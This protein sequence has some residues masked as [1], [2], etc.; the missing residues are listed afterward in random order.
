MSASPT[1]ERAK[2]PGL[3]Q[4]RL[5]SWQQIAGKVK[6]EH[7]TKPLAT[8]EAKLQV[9]T[10]GVR[11][12]N[13]PRFGNPDDVFRLALRSHGANVGA[14][15]QLSAPDARRGARTSMVRTQWEEK[16]AP[17]L[18]TWEASDSDSEDEQGPSKV[19]RSFKNPDGRDPHAPSTSGANGHAA[20]SAASKHE[21]SLPP[22]APAAAEGSA[23]NPASSQHPLRIPTADLADVDRMPCTPAAAGSAVASCSEGGGEDSF[24]VPRAEQLLQALRDTSSGSKSR[25]HAA[26]G[27][28]GGSHTESAWS[29][30]RTT[31]LMVEVPPMVPSA[32]S[33]PDSG[34]FPGTRS[35]PQSPGPLSATVAR[36]SRW[37]RRGTR[38]SSVAEYSGGGLPRP[39]LASPPPPSPPAFAAASE[40][41]GLE[42][43]RTAASFTCGQDAR[44]H[45]R[46]MWG[47]TGTRADPGRNPAAAIPSSASPRPGGGDAADVWSPDGGDGNAGSAGNSPT[48]RQG[49]PAPQATAS[50]GISRRGSLGYS[51]GG[52]GG[53]GGAGDGGHLFSQISRSPLRVAPAQEWVAVLDGPPL[54]P[55]GSQ[56]LFAAAS[57]GASPYTVRDPGSPGLAGR[58]SIFAGSG[59]G[60]GGGM[61][62]AEERAVRSSVAAAAAA[63]VNVA[64]TRGTFGA[65]AA[66]ALAKL[67]TGWFLPTPDR[68]PPP[69]R[70]AR[71]SPSR[72]ASRAG[73]RTPS[74]TGQ[75]LVPTTPS[76]PPSGA[77]RVASPARSEMASRD[78]LRPGS[79]IRRLPALSTSF[80]VPGSNT[81][82]ASGGMYPSPPASPHY[83]GFAGAPTRSSPSFSSPLPAAMSAAPG[84]GAALPAFASR[85][86]QPFP[87]PS[88]SGEAPQLGA[89]ALSSPGAARANLLSSPLRK[90]TAY[91][92]TDGAASEP[93]ARADARPATGNSA[94]AAAAA[95][96]AAA[97]GRGGSIQEMCGKL[98]DLIARGSGSSS[99]KQREAGGADGTII[100]TDADALSDD[101]A[102]DNDSWS[103]QLHSGAMAGG[104]GQ[105]L[106]LE[107]LACWAEQVE[108]VGGE[109][110]EAKARE[111]EQKLERAGLVGDLQ[112]L[113][114]RGHGVPSASTGGRG[115]GNGGPRKGMMDR[116]RHALGAPAG[117]V[118]EVEVE[119]AD[120]GRTDLG[121]GA[122]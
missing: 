14:S 87:P 66:E 8:H 33:S 122:K 115:A 37:F 38:A 18:L 58:T 97:S 112:E 47:S 119:R 32:D 103:G 83:G 72:S 7:I 6:R 68:T 9:S 30:P 99:G 85:S 79:A 89:S 67:P 62:T 71:S 93:L 74:V 108:Q 22:V 40:S 39:S 50:G 44:L 56:P 77:T 73:L 43:S 109:K 1:R 114:A 54:S 48:P 19:N 80:G 100:T 65:A 10:D 86:P 59:G 4:D 31:A 102:G 96:A 70:G 105:Q 63:V 106:E 94:S 113:A 81:N 3:E 20:N 118:W 49:P 61:N 98:R 60:G 69:S 91:P 92:S 42:V 120:A 101:G 78:G 57:M 90:H 21:S 25:A 27:S 35:V 45:P 16:V 29:A 17:D 88:A 28:A 53:G 52:G 75:P 82:P 12:V 36:P 95:A 26:A 24:V 34:P 116:L 2:T 76:T 23:T 107:S 84:S 13:S 15:S 64:A 51:F 121:I 5:K 104:R 55:S 110:D 41:N 117:A 46:A 111:A 11:Q